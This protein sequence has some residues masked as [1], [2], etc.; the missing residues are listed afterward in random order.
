MIPRIVELT[1]AAAVSYNVLGPDIRAL[2]LAFG[3]K[4]CDVGVQ[5]L[6][7]AHLQA[8]LLKATRS[9][10]RATP[11]RCAKSPPV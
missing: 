4:F 11:F 7:T 9:L 5:I 8:E 2:R 6:P 3:T 1:G 10:C